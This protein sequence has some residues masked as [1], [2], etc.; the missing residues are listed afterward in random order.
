MRMNHPHIDLNADAGESYGVWSLGH[1]AALFGLLALLGV[2]LGVIA[3]SHGWRWPA[4][5]R[6]AGWRRRR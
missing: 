6:W 1:D 4:W 2:A 5:G 3:M